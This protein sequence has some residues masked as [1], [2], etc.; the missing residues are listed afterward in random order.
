MSPFRN[1]Q[2]F[3]G[4]K[5]SCD[6]Y[7]D[8]IRVWAFITDSEIEKQGITIALSFPENLPSGIRKKKLTNF[9]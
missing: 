6:H 9:A 7:V 5:K 3:D 1:P 4:V 8:E 2:S